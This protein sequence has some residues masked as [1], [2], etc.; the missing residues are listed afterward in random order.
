MGAM[1]VLVSLRTWAPERAGDIGQR[2]MNHVFSTGLFAKAGLADSAIGQL[3]VCKTDRSRTMAYTLLGVLCEESPD[4]V[5]RVFSDCLMEL[6]KRI[7]P[8]TGWAYSPSLGERSSTG[9]V[10]L[11]NL[12]NTCYLNSTL[13]HMRPEYRCIGKEF[14]RMCISR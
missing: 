1:K 2:L 9:L 3:P 14:V 7:N 10:G 6:S 4:N 8:V 12:G 5:T 13:Q 11:N